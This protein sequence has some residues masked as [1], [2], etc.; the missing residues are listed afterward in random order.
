MRRSR[1]GLALLLAGSVIFSV[2]IGLVYAAELPEKDISLE[3]EEMVI[4]EED[5]TEEDESEINEIEPENAYD[6]SEMMISEEREE[7]ESIFIQNFQDENFRQ[8]LSEVV[9]LNHD[10]EL[11]F[12]ERNAVTVLNLNDKGI[13][14]LDGL[15]YFPLLEEL[16]CSGNSLSG[17]YLNENPRLKVLECEQNLVKINRWDYNMV[18]DREITYAKERMTNIYNVECGEFC[19]INIIDFSK[20]GSYDW[21]CGNGFFIHVILKVPDLIMH[22]K[23]GDAIE[24]EYNIDTQAL[25]FSGS[26]NMYDYSSYYSSMTLPPEWSCWKDHI[27]EIWFDDEITHIGDGAFYDF[28]NMQC[29]LKM[30]EKLESVGQYAFYGCRRICGDLVFSDTTKEIGYDAFG[31]CR[32]LRGKLILGA[33]IE[34]IGPEAF[35]YCGFTGKLELP[36]RCPRI[37]SK[38]FYGCSGLTGNLIIPSD[39]SILFDS[40]SGCTGLNGVVWFKESSDKVSYINRG[41]FWGCYNIKSVVIEEGNRKI[42]EDAFRGCNP[43]MIF[44]GIPNSETEQCVKENGFIFEP[45]RAISIT[46]EQRNVKGRKNDEKVLSIKADGCGIIFRWQIY[47]DEKWSD[48]KVGGNQCYQGI[49][50]PALRFLIKEDE[51]QQYRCIVTDIMGNEKISN[52]IESVMIPENAIYEDVPEAS[53]WRYEAIKYVKDH[54]IMNGI[55]GTRNFAPDEPLTRAMFATIIYRMEGSPK[56][57][58]SAKFPD[59]PDGNYFSVPI[60][61]ANKAGIING[62]SNTGLFG[63]RENITREDMVVIMYRYCKVKGLASGDRADL[64]RFPDADQI[65]GYAKEAVRWAV[66]NGIINGRSNTGMLDPK[67]NASRVETAAI[68]QRFMTK[69]K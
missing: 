50:T 21:D 31:N 68:I 51:M 15:K 45:L 19:S 13:K 44:Y 69:I 16:Y 38:A 40:F 37:G 52:V 34:T 54:G 5:F 14:C 39:M 47:E 27:K 17:L 6:E 10:G 56:A 8:Y 53:G 59:V 3:S 12:E 25:L 55:S 32:G 42:N 43:D 49:D 57:S 4:F 65:S 64:S 33:G 24:W 41:A 1:K 62:H 48:L 7:T 23:A 18:L 58:Y 22:G 35:S 9:D 46:E 2:N 26:G 11:S 36:E 61:W 20:D 30:P 66:A 63:T 28:Q 67:G 29:S 60:I